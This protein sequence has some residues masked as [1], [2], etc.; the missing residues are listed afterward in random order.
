M[1]RRGFEP[2]PPQFAS[3][4]SYKFGQTD[5][6]GSP[7]RLPHAF[8]RGGGTCVLTRVTP[9]PD[10]ACRSFYGGHKHT[11]AGRPWTTFDFPTPPHPY[12]NAAAP[13]SSLPFP[14]APATTIWFVL[15]IFAPVHTRF[16]N[17][18]PF[19]HTF[20]FCIFFFFCCILFVVVPACLCL[21]FCYFTV[22]CIKFVTQLWLPFVAF[23]PTHTHPSYPLV[24]HLQLLPH[25]AHSVVLAGSLQRA[26]CPQPWI[27]DC[28][29]LP[30]PVMPGCYIYHRGLTTHATPAPA[31]ISSLRTRVPFAPDLPR[32][33][34]LSP[35]TTLLP[36]TTHAAPPP[37]GPHT[38]SPL[39]V[40]VNHTLCSV[41]T[42]LKDT[43]AVLLPP[44]TP[45][46][47]LVH[48]RVGS[49]PHTRWAGRCY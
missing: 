25:S 28:T 26:V 43:T 17:I 9:P 33:R 4:S 15:Y 27:P 19:S 41:L 8:C 30:R 10:Y 6:T 7:F 32:R 16:H 11:N 23:R 20:F 44:H 22:L 3:S 24:A 39:A 21:A 31:H 13:R 36:Y 5:A 38:A 29:Y 46:S 47:C 1:L 37:G 45:I 34:C 48:F 2:S 40:R 18:I 35:M 49:S 42:A 12:K 14:N